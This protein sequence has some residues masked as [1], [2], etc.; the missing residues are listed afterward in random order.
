MILDT[1]LEPI[2][3]FWNILE[4]LPLL[5][6]DGLPKTV[7]V[8]TWTFWTN[9]IHL[10]TV[11]WNYVTERWYSY[12]LVEVLP[13]WTTSNDPMEYNCQLEGIAPDPWNDN[14]LTIRIVSTKP[15]KVRKGLVLRLANRSASLKSQVALWKHLV[16]TG[17]PLSMTTTTPPFGQQPK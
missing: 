2:V 7:S 11:E 9:E 5:F 14:A 12:P 17:Q 1:F 8:L 13:C 16:N 4:P 3:L 6:D 10:E 15:S